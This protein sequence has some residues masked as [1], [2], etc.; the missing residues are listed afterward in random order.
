[1][2]F[3]CNFIE[4]FHQLNFTIEK[5]F[6]N[7]FELA[8]FIFVSFFFSDHFAVCHFKWIAPRRVKNHNQNDF[9]QN[10]GDTPV[11]E[12]ST[13]NLS[14]SLS[15][16]SWVS[17]WHSVVSEIGIFQDR[18]QTS[19]RLCIGV[20]WHMGKATR[21]LTT[22]QTA[23]TIITKTPRPLPRTR[24]QCVFFQINKFSS[25]QFVMHRSATTNR[26]Q[27]KS[28]RAYRGVTL[29][30]RFFKIKEYSRLMF[31]ALSL[32]L[33]KSYSHRQTALHCS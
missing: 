2:K 3:F 13:R 30:F 21:K 16:M 14:L 20:T 5:C 27:I 10:F 15:A 6:A 18:L 4:W 28:A 32:D 7:R 17:Q 25:K 9:G 29:L 1:M 33:R 8:F 23:R 19:R 12:V 11:I 26:I 22:R 24:L 31:V